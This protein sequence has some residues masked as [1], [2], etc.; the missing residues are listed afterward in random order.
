MVTV[1]VTV[2]LPL[3]AVVVSHVYQNVVAVGN[4]GDVSVVPSTDSVNVL[5]VPQSAVVEI[6][7]DCAPLTP[8]AG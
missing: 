5:V 7:T 3:P 1:T 2:R 6:P 4:V 8:E